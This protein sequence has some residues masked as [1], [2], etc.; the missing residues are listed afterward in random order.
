MTLI[1]FTNSV[2]DSFHYHYKILYKHTHTQY[3][4]K[5]PFMYVMNTV[6]SCSA[7]KYCY[8]YCQPTA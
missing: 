7:E 3:M 1:N 2:T 6:R 4:D 5:E 8:N